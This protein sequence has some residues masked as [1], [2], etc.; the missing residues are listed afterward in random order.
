[1]YICITPLPVPGCTPY[2]SSSLIRNRLPLGHYSR[3]KPR[4]I[5]WSGGGGA[6]S[7]ARHPG[8]L[9]YLLQGLRLGVHIGWALSH[10]P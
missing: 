8:K 2:R 9:H 7:Y 5:W 4:V 6:F 3:A 1:M 10:K